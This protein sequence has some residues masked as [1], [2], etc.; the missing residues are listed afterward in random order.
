MQAPKAAG[1]SETRTIPLPPRLLAL[2]NQGPRAEQSDYKALLAVESA[3]LCAGLQ[4]HE[5]IDALLPVAWIATMR[6]D[7][8]H[9]LLQDLRR[10]RAK[11]LGTLRLAPVEEAWKAFENLQP[12]TQQ[13]LVS[14]SQCMRRRGALEAAQ[15]GVS[16]SVIATLLAAEPLPLARQV[17][18]WAA[19]RAAH[20]KF[21]RSRDEA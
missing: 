5:I 18:Q 4:D 19:W 11:G 3:L 21:G 12:S 1:V 6:P 17:A 10:L 14:A 2:L 8:P 7:M 15:A 20:P 13:R 16:A 9:W